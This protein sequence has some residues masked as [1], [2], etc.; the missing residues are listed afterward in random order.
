M[1][2]ELYTKYLA[3]R[4]DL[5]IKTQL[6]DEVIFGELIDKNT[7]K[8]YK[9]QD[10]IPRIIE[11]ENYTENFGFQ[12][13]KFRESQLDSFSGRNLS[14]NRVWNHTKWKPKDMVGKKVLEIGSGAGRFTEI[15]LDAGCE[16]VTFDFSNA[17]D[18]NLKNNSAKGRFLILQASI[19]DLP[20]KFEAFDYVFC[21]GVLQHLPEPELGLQRIYK[22]LKPHGK[23][24]V[25]YYLKTKKLIPHNQS[26][27]FWRRWTTKMKPET[28]YK[29][30]SFYMPIWLPIDSLIRKVPVLGPKL[31]SVMLIP[32]W[33]YLGWGFTYKERLEWAIMDT[34]DALGAQYDYPKTKE[35]L[36][37][38]LDVLSATSYEV[39][40]GSNGLVG[41][42]I[43]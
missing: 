33:N 34:F 37:K 29:V 2:I 41:N 8:I 27:Y 36:Q 16:L 14:F 40:Y 22:Y 23:M 17:V 43:K 24:S 35:E 25:D 32:C 3:H 39:F 9:I 6:Q 18:A 15:L 31:L 30:I 1:N 26:K 21:Y 12:W 13:N 7:G 38:D 5:K 28:L 20:F 11:G 4:Y 42:V 10:S 19:Y